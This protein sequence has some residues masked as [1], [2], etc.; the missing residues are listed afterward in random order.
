MKRRYNFKKICKGCVMARSDRSACI[1]VKK[2]KEEMCPCINCLVKM[3][4]LDTCDE[5]DKVVALLMKIGN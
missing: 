1:I 3:I 2:Q 4:C 5:R